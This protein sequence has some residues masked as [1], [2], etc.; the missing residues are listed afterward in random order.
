MEIFKRWHTTRVAVKFIF[1][2]KSYYLVLYQEE[3]AEQISS[4]NTN[5]NTF[6]GFL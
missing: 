6:W 4:G 3:Y 1:C 5:H 2:A